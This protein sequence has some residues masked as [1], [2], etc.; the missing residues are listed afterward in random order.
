MEIGQQIRVT[1]DEVDIP[2]REGKKLPLLTAKIAVFL[3]AYSGVR[4]LVLQRDDDPSGRNVT[5]VLCY[6]TT[7]NATGLL[8][9]YYH[10]RRCLRLYLALMAEWATDA[11]RRKLGNTRPASRRIT[12]VASL[13]RVFTETYAENALSRFPAACYAI[14]GLSAWRRT[15]GWL[16]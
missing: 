10:Y 1:A 9:A 5:A 7:L 12:A 14:G 3:R 8:K 11:V 13:K 4:P 2:L 15:P 16:E 6:S